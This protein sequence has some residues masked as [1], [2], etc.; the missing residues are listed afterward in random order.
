M[1]HGPH[2]AGHMGVSAHTRPNQLIQAQI[3]R[4]LQLMFCMSL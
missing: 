4:D 1:C 2:Y 3:N